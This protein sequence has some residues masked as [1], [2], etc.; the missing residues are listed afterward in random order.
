M[1][2]L[3]S[4][5]PK[6]IGVL[7]S[8]ESLWEVVFCFQQIEINNYMRM[9]LTFTVKNSEQEPES[10]Q[11]SIFKRLSG[12]DLEY[13]P[14]VQTGS[15]KAVIMTAGE[16]EF[17]NLCDFETR[18]EAFG[19][20]HDLRAFIRAIYRKGLPI[21]AFGYA[22]PLLVK[23]IQGIC[24]TGPV[25]TVGNNPK[26]Q[27]GIEATGSQAITTRPTEVIIDHSNKL[28]TSG[29]QLASNRLIEV[30]ADCENMFTALTELIK[31]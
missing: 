8:T 29:G 3:R 19:V 11:N 16:S 26:L 14:E 6:R 10:T 22:V 9:A 23:S 25:V 12:I 15:L 4:K 21:G 31:G 20:D 1:P 27:A 28:V 18:G 13:A 5:I 17:N 24:N 2:E 30:A 7:L